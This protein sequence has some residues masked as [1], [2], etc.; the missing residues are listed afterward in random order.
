MPWHSSDGLVIFECDSCDVV[1][2][3]DVATIRSTAHPTAHD[4][5]FSLCYRYMQGI[6]WR[7]FKRTG[8]PWSYHCPTCSPQAES[9]HRDH[10]RLENERDRI[11]TRNAREA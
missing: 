3:C 7:S 5:D 11:K 4:T 2:D 6:G 1:V 10:Q 8:R 9:E